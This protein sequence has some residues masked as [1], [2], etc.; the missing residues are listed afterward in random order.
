MR[1]DAVTGS[2][3]TLACVVVWI[4]CLKAFLACVVPP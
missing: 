3:G 4:G 2:I 1:S